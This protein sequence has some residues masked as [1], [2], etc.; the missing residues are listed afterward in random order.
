MKTINIGFHSQADIFE[1]NFFI[2]IKTT[3]KLVRQG[4][5][6]NSQLVYLPLARLL[7]KPLNGQRIMK[8]NTYFVSGVPELLNLP[9]MYSL[10]S[11]LNL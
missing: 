4:S 6:D 10:F 3:F 1:S 2:Y 8:M 7:M 11:Y 9:M 5:Q